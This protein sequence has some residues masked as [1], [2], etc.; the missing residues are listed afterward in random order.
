MPRPYSCI[1]GSGANAAY[2]RSRCSGGKR[3]TVQAQ[4]DSVAADLASLQCPSKEA[5]HLRR[6][7]GQGGKAP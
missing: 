2:T 1:F 5:R 7:Q 4:L 3:A 6:A